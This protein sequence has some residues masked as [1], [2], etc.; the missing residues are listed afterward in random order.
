MLD[1]Q[2]DGLHRVIIPGVAT[3]PGKLNV[4]SL[5]VRPQ[6]RTQLRI[7]FL[8]SS[9]SYYR[10]ADFD[11]ATGDVEQA[12]AA[13]AATI[14]PLDGGWFV[15]SFGMRP[16]EAKAAI[17]VDLLALPDRVKYPGEPGKGLILG[18]PSLQVK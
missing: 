17:L 14:V 4:I 15:V 1:T 5:F 6:A 12:D 2:G 7:E 10:R 9:G 8:G 13:A 3:Y 11:L 16:T 18:A